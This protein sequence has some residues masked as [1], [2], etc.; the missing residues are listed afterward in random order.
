MAAANDDEVGI[1]YQPG[2][3]VGAPVTMRSSRNASSEETMSLP[4][5]VAMTCP[6]GSPVVIW[7]SA[8]GPGEPIG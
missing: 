4:A 5:I 2:W 6:I 8:A 7:N 3:T 1:A